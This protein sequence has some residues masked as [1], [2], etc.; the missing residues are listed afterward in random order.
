MSAKIESAILKA[1]P[2]TI[3]YPSE[4][5]IT[6]HPRGVFDENLGDR[7][8]EFMEW[9]ERIADQPFNRFID[10]SGLSSVRL[11]VGHAFQSAERR[12]TGYRGDPVK[13]AFFA[14]SFAGLGFA[15]LYAALMKG[16]QIQVGVFGSRSDAAE[17]L[18][19]SMEFLNP[20]S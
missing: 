14:D 16:A 17:W 20:P 2:N 4:R 15:R 9:E 11:K 1:F 19:V 7:I 13:S 10:L 18:E 6:W 3:Y 5:V 8:I 12:R